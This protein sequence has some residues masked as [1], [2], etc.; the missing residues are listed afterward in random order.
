MHALHPAIVPLILTNGCMKG[1]N[2]GSTKIVVQPEEP[3]ASFVLY[4]NFA[5]AV[6]VDCS[7]MKIH[8][9]RDMKITVFGASWKTGQQFNPYSNRV[10]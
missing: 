1:I 2:L 8:K 9:I 4:V 3:Y 6:Q 5:G 10:L 7:V